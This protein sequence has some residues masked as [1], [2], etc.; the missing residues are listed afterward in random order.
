M[1]SRWLEQTIRRY[2]HRRWT[3]DNNR[4]VFP[5]DWGLE[6][7]GGPRVAPDAAP[8]TPPG[9]VALGAAAA[10]QQS[11]G[12][13]PRAFLEQ[14]T[15]QTIASSDDWYATT[16]ANDYKLEDGLLTYSSQ[17]TSPFPE[18]NTVYARFFPA[19]CSGPAVVVLPQWNAKWDAQVNV[20]RWLNTMGITALRLSL[21]YHDRRTVPGHERADQLVGPN[22][23]LTIQANRQA[24]TDVRRAVRWLEQV[25]YS[26]IGILGTSIGS[27]IGFIALAHEP[28]L[29]AGAF[30][31][32]STYF[33]DVVRTGLT[34]MHVWEGL[35]ARVTADE[36]RRYWAAISPFPYIP[37][38]RGTSQRILMV[39]GK[40]DPTFWPEF[41]EQV[42]GEMRHHGVPHESLMLPCGHYS[43][44]EAPFKFIVGGRFAGFLFGALT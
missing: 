34:T 42:V 38:M 39:S 36:I 6:H 16:P 12:A 20:C 7:I 9:L 32:V 21:P 41:S 31:H 1:L 40:Y 30:L 22:I 5:F 18:N 24:V 25:G 27:S 11:N 4:R 43:L 35:R 29:R 8:T 3:V 44:G 37:R 14:F 26:R 10:K 28:A 33:G 23:G 17:I 19:K 15:A 13:D 2:E